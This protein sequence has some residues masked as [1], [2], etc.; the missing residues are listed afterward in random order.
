[1]LEAVVITP[2]LGLVFPLDVMWASHAV[3]IDAPEFFGIQQPERY[4]N[5]GDNVLTGYGFDASGIPSLDIIVAGAGYVTSCV[6]PTPDDGQWQCVWNATT[7]NGGVPPVDGDSFDLE[8]LPTDGQGLDPLSAAPLRLGKA[9]TADADTHTV[10]VDA[11]P[12]SGAY[13]AAT[14]ATYSGTVIAAADL[15]FS[16]VVTDNHA[17][18]RV[19]VCV[20]GACGFAGVQA[21][22]QPSSVVTDIAAAPAP[23]P[24]C[25]STNLVRTF[26][27][28]ESFTVG[29]VELGINANHERRND[30][31]ATLTAPDGTG[32][33]VLGPREGTPFEAQNLDIRLFD[34]AGAGQHEVKTSDHT[35]APIF[36]RE[37]RPY[38]PLAALRGQGAAGTWTLTLCDSDPITKTGAYNR[39]EL[40][41]RPADTGADHGTWS[42]KVSDLDA[43]DGVPY[44][45]EA[46]AIDRAGNRSAA[47]F[48]RAGGTLTFLRDNVAPD[49]TAAQTTS[50]IAIM[51]D[52]PPA[53]ILEGTATDGKR[54]VRINAL[55]QDP[56]G[57]ISHRQVAQNGA[58]WW[59]DLALTTTGIYKI[60]IE[61]FD[62]A[63]NTTLLGPY[64]LEAIQHLIYLPIIAHAGA[65]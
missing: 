11:V 29:T 57:R 16:G 8:L 47:N 25:E 53:R 1:M 40:I 65:R 35:A 36:N 39:A 59:F 30:L 18:D 45:V 62:E 5:P 21:Q 38:E 60:W 20:N 54:V 58:S 64:E 4:V 32:V 12:P 13:N 33:Q 15:V 17:I 6:D 7:A 22:A 26:V 52:Q 56:A 24:A 9:R 31:W 46:Y 48:G 3:D 44:S 37:A 19:E 34:A 2:T 51:P 27:V 10:I 43:A 61:A 28:T 42:Y 55:I 41:V 23:I 50:T 49:L 63:E 14:T